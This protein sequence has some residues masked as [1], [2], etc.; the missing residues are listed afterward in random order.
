MNNG[1][2]EYA[3][4]TSCDWLLRATARFYDRIYAVDHCVS[5][6]SVL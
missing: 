2:E 5:I 3:I 1:I 6:L 4:C